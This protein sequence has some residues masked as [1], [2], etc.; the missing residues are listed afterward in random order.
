MNSLV[1]A[2]T[3]DKPVLTQTE[4]LREVSEV[5]EARE[6]VQEMYASKH[7]P[8]TRRNYDFHWNRFV[9]WCQDKTTRQRDPGIPEFSVMSLIPVT[10]EQLQEEYPFDGLEQVLLLYIASE[11]VAIAPENLSDKDAEEYIKENSI[12]PSSLSAILSALKSKI[13]D[14]Q[15][16]VKW[17]PSTVLTGSV[18]GMRRAL[19]KVYG[20]ARQATPLLL[21]HIEQLAQRL[22]ANNEPLTVT[23]DSVLVE[24]IAAGTRRAGRCT[25][26][27]IRDAGEYAFGGRS[28]HRCP[29]D[30]ARHVRATHHHPRPEPQGA[31]KTKAP[32]MTLIRIVCSP[33][34]ST[35]SSS[36]TRR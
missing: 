32:S 18:T 33:R 36:A 31:T 5:T 26:D 29:L 23:I 7:A 9:N 10:S 16:R 17:E 25:L 24:M 30:R 13:G 28:Q 3:S 8:N 2:P 20:E 15:P 11:F 34:R 22:S 19:G 35:P 1:K 12:A 4:I 6:I 14:L 21:G 27:S